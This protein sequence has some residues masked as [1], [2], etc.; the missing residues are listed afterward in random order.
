MTFFRTIETLPAKLLVF[1]IIGGFE[2]V[3][4]RSG[5]EDIEM[6]EGRGFLDHRDALFRPYDELF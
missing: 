3:S 6:A 1:L 4:T 5:A 2:G